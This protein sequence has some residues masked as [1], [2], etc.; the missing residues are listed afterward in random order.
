MSGFSTDVKAHEPRH[1]SVAEEAPFPRA[2]LCMESLL[3][4]VGG[5]HL[6]GADICSH[7]NPGGGG[8]VHATAGR[9]EG[10]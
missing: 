9:Q 7:C 4:F 2:Q 8:R 5:A 3:G 6:G 10:R 1:L